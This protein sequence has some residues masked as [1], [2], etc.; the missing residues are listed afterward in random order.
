MDSIC[1]VDGEW[2]EGNPKLT[3]PMNQAF[4][5][6][7]TVFDG[8]RAFDGC[9]PDVDLH[10]ERLINS[11]RSL[12]MEP[13]KTAAEITELCLE[14]ARKFETGAELYIRP[15]YYASGGFLLP[16]PETTTFVLAVYRSPMPDFSGMGVCLSTRRR[17]AREMAPTDAKATCLYPNTARAL[18]EAQDR[19]FDNAV[20]LDANGNVAEFATSNLWIVKDGIAKTPAV[21]G[22]FL[23]GVTRQR[24]IQLLRDDGVEVE[25]TT[26]T[27]ADVM[28]ADEVFSTGNYGKVTPVVRVEDRDLQRGPLTNK[29]RDLYW[30]YSKTTSAL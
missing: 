27:F 22:T 28:D 4:W 5:L 23:N 24:T 9:A 25:E 21:N 26:L 13:T 12:M 20:I 19:G 1:Y 30:D 8:A 16:D 18:K 15:M 11:A 7:T 29:A 14:G 6:G 3:G 2:V 10:C 17:P